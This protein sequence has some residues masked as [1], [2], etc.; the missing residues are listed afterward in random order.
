MLANIVLLTPVLVNVE[1]QS[2]ASVSSESLRNSLTESRVTLHGD[3]IVLSCDV[4]VFYSAVVYSNSF[5]VH[6]PTSIC[7]VKKVL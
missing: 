3:S 4:E 2:G 6:G 1:K 5:M 7:L